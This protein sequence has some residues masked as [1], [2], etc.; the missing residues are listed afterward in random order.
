[1]KLEKDRLLAKVESLE[2][3]LGQVAKGNEDNIGG[4]GSA[5]DLSPA[6]TQY[7]K[8]SAGNSPG[9]LSSTKQLRPTKSSLGKIPT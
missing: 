3:N 5:I 6:K 9:K 8:F 4:S 2:I 1:M 7:S